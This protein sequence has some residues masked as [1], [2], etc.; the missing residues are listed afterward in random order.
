[1]SSSTPETRA[2]QSSGAEH[3][4]G[5]DDNASWGLPSAP[6][7]GLRGRLA[8]SVL[9]RIL[10][11]VPVTAKLA[12][13]EVY[14]EGGPTLE[15]TEP[16]AFFARLAASPMIGL[17]EAYM[18]AEWSAGADTDLADALTPFAE[19]LTDLIPPVFYR[20]RHAVLPR[21]INPENTKS[22]ARKNIERH[23][24]LSNDMFASF[25][26]P[27]LS[28]SSA[29]FERLEPAPTTADLEAAQLRKVDAIL[30]EAGVRE[31]TRLLEIGTGWGTLAIRAAQRGAQV[32]TITISAEQAELAQQR[33]DAAGIADR[34][35]IALR[36]YRD[37][38]GL[39]D[40]IV[41]VEMIEAV[42]EK[43]WPTYFSAIDSLLAPGGK[44]AIQA[45]LLEH[46]RYL[47]TR[48]TYTWIHKYIF[49]GGLL[50]S[51]RAIEEVVHAHTSLAVTD[52]SPLGQHYAHTLR[53]WREQF[54]AGWP[55]VSALG[56]GETFRRMWEF[57]LAY[58]EAG[59]RAGY[60]EVA[61][62]R[63]E[64]PASGGS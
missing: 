57:Y 42:G 61:Q 10:R 23:Y 60:L 59:F 49:P 3:L 32:T 46:H 6:A 11:K 51:V 8:K 12:T 39:F 41:S 19:R 27:S 36:D 52:V 38:T 20:M 24:D 26:D 21:G 48:D 53:L 50:P 45:I 4:A 22:G 31:G 35:E 29:L 58:C 47:A 2:P 14:G 25:L 43:Y 34:V 37:Q 64:R 55:T 16:D 44:A 40:A 56:F 63:L 30:D 33:V 54:L 15:V 62:I 28:Y 5:P 7:Y 17:G 13:G 18:A 1:M 9:R